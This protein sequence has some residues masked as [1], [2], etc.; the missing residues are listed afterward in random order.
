[1]DSLGLE[2]AQESSLDT[3]IQINANR[4]RFGSDLRMPGAVS[5]M[6]HDLTGFAPAVLAAGRG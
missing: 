5:S 4:T 2:V 6:S 3:M 1:M